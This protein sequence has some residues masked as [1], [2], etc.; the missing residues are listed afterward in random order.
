MR[1]VLRHEIVGP[2]RVSVINWTANFDEEDDVSPPP[3]LYEV[4]V[5][6]EGPVP[7]NEWCSRVFRCSVRSSAL[8]KFFAVTEM[9]KHDPECRIF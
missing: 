3:E 6:H 1:G 5:A 4:V 2:F 9:L 7:H 8:K